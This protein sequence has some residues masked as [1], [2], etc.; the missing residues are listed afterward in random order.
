MMLS[1]RK[2]RRVH[3]MAIKN[4]VSFELS[5]E[6]DV[7]GDQHRRNTSV[8]RQEQGAAGRRSQHECE[9]REHSAVT[10]RVADAQIPG[11]AATISAAGAQACLSFYAS[12]SP[13]KSQ[14]A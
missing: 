9:G 11:G 14:G 13:T 1:D 4:S 12:T 6:A 3:R 7:A 10:A 2:S 5:T 8:D